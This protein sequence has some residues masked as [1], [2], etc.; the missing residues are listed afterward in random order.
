MR[1][2]GLQPV[3]GEGVVNL[4]MPYDTG[5]FYAPVTKG[6]LPVVSLPAPTPAPRPALDNR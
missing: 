2:L 6:G 1:S 4:L 5:V 3:E